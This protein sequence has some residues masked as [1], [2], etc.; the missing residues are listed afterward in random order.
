MNESN[1]RY[2]CTCVCE[3]V[4]VCIYIV[5]LC[6]YIYD[7]VNVCVCIC[8]CLRECQCLMYFPSFFSSLFDPLCL[9][10]HNSAYSTLLSVQRLSEL[11]E[12]IDYLKNADDPSRRNTI[13]LLWHERLKGLQV[14][15]YTCVYVRVCARVR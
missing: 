6:V 4:C 3:C 8:V 5:C 10:Q 13:R 1:D 11:E 2:V 7:A 15:V 12:V 9:S 14:C